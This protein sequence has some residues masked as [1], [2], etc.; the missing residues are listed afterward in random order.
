MRR[1][2]CIVLFALLSNPAGGAAE[3]EVDPLI[4]TIRGVGKNGEGN[5]AAAAAW[6]K[7]SLASVDQ[8]RQ[9]LAGMKD[10]DPLAVNWLRAAAETIAERQVAQRE[11]L[12]TGALEAFL[13][14]VTQ[15]PRARRLAYELIARV[16]PGAEQRLIPTLADDPSVE[17]R[18]DAVTLLIKSA[19]G[20]DAK[21]QPDAARAAYER[22]LAAARDLDQIAACAAKLKE[23]GGKLDLP[24]HF[25]F[26]MSWK[27][28]GPFDNTNTQG[29]D[30]A[31]PPESNFDSNASYAG[32]AGEV[33]WIDHS[34][35]DE[36][37]LVDLNKALGKHMGAI[38]YAYA[39]FHSPTA[40]TVD[41]RL[42]C[43]NG[44][45]IWLNGQLLTAN[46]VYHTGMQIDQYIAAGALRP[47][48]NTILIKVAQ[49]EQKEDWAQNWHFQFRICDSVGTAIA[50]RK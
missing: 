41:L 7:L 23:L 44:N 47:G 31:Y 6:K 37:G 33:R 30:V 21:V 35:T 43:A 1:I 48:K 17:L 25:G 3:V 32:K 29:F 45:K 19:E 49:N 8:L 5:R 38:A 15:S 27:L 20:I 50:S 26:I 18:R 4:A 11:P 9:I 16:D 14:D 39:E 10:A 36:H 12:P 42:G 24:Q 40:R 34:T 28:I 2:F 46:H 13:R 22:A